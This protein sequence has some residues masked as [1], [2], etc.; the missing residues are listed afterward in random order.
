MDEPVYTPPV[1]EPVYEPPPME[2]ERES[3][4]TGPPLTSDDE[5]AAPEEP[6]KKNNRTAIFAG[7]GCLLIFFC[8]VVTWLL[9][10]YGDQII[11][12]L[13]F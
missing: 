8:L 1:E 13:G 10:T 11:T 6:P 5:F 7:C 2:L 3:T 9:W 4:F 12:S